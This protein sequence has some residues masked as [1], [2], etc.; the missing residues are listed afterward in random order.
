ML[1]PKTYTALMKKISNPLN[2][3][4]TVADVS[5]TATKVGEFRAALRKGTTP[6]EAAYRARDLMDFARAGVS[7]RE[8]NKVVAFLN[9]NIQGKSKLYRAF[10]KNPTRFT[11]KAVAAVTIPTIGAIVAQHTYAN[12]K[13][14]EVLDDAPQ[15]LKDTF[16]LVPVPGTNQIARIPKPFDLAFAFSNTLERAVDY[17]Y[18]NDKEAFNGWIKQGFSQASIPVMLTGIA[19]IVEGMANYSFFRQSPIIP[20]REESV[21]FP[22]QYDVN[23]TET[24]KFIG[25]GVDK[26]TGG[27]GAFRNFGSPRVID[28]TIQGF[29]GGLGTY[30]TSAVDLF[31][32]GVSTKNKPERPA[33]N[34][35]Q[36]PLARAFLVNQ[37]GSGESI[38]RLYSLREKLSKDRGSA[39][40]NN[41]PYLDEGKYKNIN[42]ITKQLGEINKQ[43]RFIEN[44]PSLSAE[45]KRSTLDE[46][47]R[48]RNTFA[49]NAAEQTR[50]WK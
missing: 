13:Q 26:L 49:R 44:N 45:E 2:T 43:I 40:Q 24:A 34:L 31:V 8:A 16:Y 15:W 42:S 39:K 25:R 33:K 47:I 17:I 19:P 37:S 18:K 14:R 4:R 10:K 29:T 9:A 41:E 50:G 48:Q 6:Q 5:E 30:A 46:L 1:N 35:D 36:K 27:E 38:D 22:D 20:K 7:V 23:T 21:N 28:S 11:G 12:T 3:L 32:D